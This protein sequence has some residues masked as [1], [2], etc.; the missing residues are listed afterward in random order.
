MDQYIALA[1]S[2]SGRPRVGDDE[3]PHLG[4][5]PASGYRRRRRYRRRYRR[6]PAGLCRRNGVGCPRLADV[7]DDEQFA[8]GDAPGPGQPTAIRIT[9]VIVAVEAVALCGG[10]VA[11]V[12]AT[13]VATAHRVWIPLAL[14]GLA[15]AT[16]LVLLSCAR[17]LGAD[18]QAARTPI[19]LVQLLMLPVGYSLGIQAGRLVVGGP[20]LLAAIVVLAALFSPAVRARLD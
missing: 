13:V 20:I 18:H 14:A 19:I 9:Q 10:A 5:V 2:G 17:G 1:G 6:R 8:S 7:P 4:S 15:V 16:A 3:D 12:I 11:L